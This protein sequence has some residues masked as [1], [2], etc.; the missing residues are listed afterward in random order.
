LRLAAN[1]VPLRRRSRESLSA[2]SAD[3][4]ETANGA[5]EAA[6]CWSSSGGSLTVRLAML[7]GSFD[8]P[9]VG[10]L[11]MAVDAVEG[12]ALDRLVFIPAATQ[13]LKVGL[14][15]A[16]PEQRLD[17][18]R[19][20]VGFD[21]RFTVD[22]IETDRQGVSFSVDT[23]A[24]Y[25]GRFPAAE[26]FFLVGA[27]VVGSFGSWRTPERIAQLATVVVV[28]RGEEG[29]PAESGGGAVAVQQLRTRRID[30]SSTEVRARVRAGQSIHGFVSPAVAKYIETAG[31]YR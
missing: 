24:A 10:H 30:V 27:D 12:L 16:T 14:M 1:E 22:A 25:A 19:L 7:G 28:R 31:L 8:P 3:S 9:H 11:L 21:P 23:V 4:G 15:V 26:R 17:M 13:P 29:V 18:L 2:T 6:R 5:R 20:M